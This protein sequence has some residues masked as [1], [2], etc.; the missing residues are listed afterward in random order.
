MA[1]GRTPAMHYYA[2]YAMNSALGEALK[3]VSVVVLLPSRPDQVPD[4]RQQV[5]MAVVAQHRQEIETAAGK[6]VNPEY[7]LQLGNVEFS[8]GHKSDAL[9]YYEKGLRQA[10]KKKDESSEAAALLNMAVLQLDDRELTDKAADAAYKALEIHQRKGMTQDQANDLATVGQIWLIKRDFGR[11]ILAL[12]QARNLYENEGK[13]EKVGDMMLDLGRVCREMGETT[14]ALELLNKA[15]QRHA[16]AGDHRGCA[17]DLAEM[18]IVHNRIGDKKSALRDLQQ[19]R[20]IFSEGS[21]PGQEARTLSD[22]GRIF[23]EMGEHDQALQSL[24]QSA[25]LSQ[26][27]AERRKE[28][29]NLFYI[30]LIYKDKGSPDVGLEY[31]SKRS[32]SARKSRMPIL[33]REPYIIWEWHIKRRESNR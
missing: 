4:Y 2:T 17:E 27:K 19:A 29:D 7:L 24:T 32:I 26:R 22:M 9:R 12:E 15:Y 3:G 33:K 31:M 30:G 25:R 14:K 6:D 21:S 18:G 16:E 8:L 23:H 5:V 13:V 1:A 11:A 28:A 20:K 10:R